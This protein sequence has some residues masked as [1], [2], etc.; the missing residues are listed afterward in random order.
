MQ[1]CALPYQRKELRLLRPPTRRYLF[2]L[3][4]VEAHDGQKSALT[5]IVLLY[6]VVGI[7]GFSLN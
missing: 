2:V 4:L 5:Y 7:L 1:L 3:C 6:R